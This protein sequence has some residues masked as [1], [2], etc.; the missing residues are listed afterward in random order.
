LKIA[1][2]IPFLVRRSYGKEQPFDRTP[3]L[4]YDALDED[5]EACENSFENHAD[6]NKHIA[7]DEALDPEGDENN[8]PV[9]A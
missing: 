9:N 4:S 8:D 3:V 6:I 1:F 7:E 5:I 2:G